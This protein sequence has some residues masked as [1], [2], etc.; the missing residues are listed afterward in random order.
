MMSFM[1]ASNNLTSLKTFY[2]EE[3]QSLDPINKLREEPLFTSKYT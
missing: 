3:P 2:V 1:P